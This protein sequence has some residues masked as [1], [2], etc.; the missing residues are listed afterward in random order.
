MRA[1]YDF[2]EGLRKAEQP[3]ET[4]DPRFATDPLA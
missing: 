2:I 3:P 1:A 4:P